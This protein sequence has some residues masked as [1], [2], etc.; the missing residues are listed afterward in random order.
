MATTDKCQGIFPPEGSGNHFNH[1]LLEVI[2]ELSVPYNSHNFDLEFIVPRFDNL[3]L[4]FSKSSELTTQLIVNGFVLS[5]TLGI[6][7]GGCMM[8]PHGTAK[9]STSLKKICTMTVLS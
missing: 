4:Y 9:F 7:L 2:L 5:T 3:I 8:R 1:T 6:V